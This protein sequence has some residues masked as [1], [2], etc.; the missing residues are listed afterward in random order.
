MTYKEARQAWRRAANFVLSSDNVLYCTD[1][2][3]RKAEENMPE[4]SL[5]LVVPTTMIQE[6]LHNCHDSIEGG[7]QGVVRSYQK[8]KHDYYWIGL[9]ADV[10]KHVKSCLNCSSEA[11]RLGMCSRSDHSR[12][13]LWTL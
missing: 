7:H 10:E 9:Y 13:C 8:V 3:R 4:M 11:I 2:N 6:V 1:V 5:R 12:W